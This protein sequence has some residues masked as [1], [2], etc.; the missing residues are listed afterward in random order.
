MAI[1]ISALQK[2]QSSAPSI[3]TLYKKSGIDYDTAL[4]VGRQRNEI[5]NEQFAREQ[6]LKNA[7]EETKKYEAEAEKIRGSLLYKAESGIVGTYNLGKDIVKTVASTGAGIADI[8]ERGLGV[9]KQIEGVKNIFQKEKG[10]KISEAYKRGKREYDLSPTYFERVT[11]KSLTKEDGGVDWEQGRKFIT[12]SMEAPLYAFNAGVVVGKTLLQRA[13]ARVSSKYFATQVGAGASLQ[14]AGEY[15]EGDT[16]GE[17]ASNFGKNLVLNALLYLGGETLQGEIARKVDIKKAKESLS[18]IESK[19]GKLDDADR[20]NAL[21]ALESGVPEEK[22]IKSI[23][24]IKNEEVSAD[25]LAKKLNDI[26]DYSPENPNSLL[27]KITIEKDP[28]K[29]APL[30]EGK[31]APEDIPTVSRLLKNVETEESANAILKK[32][33]PDIQNQKLIEDISFA[34]TPEQVAR[35]LKGKA[36]D[37]TIKE[38]SPILAEIRDEGDIQRI[39]D[40][41]NVKAKSLTKAEGEL[42]LKQPTTTPP[43][44]SK[45]QLQI[46][47]LNE[48]LAKISEEENALRL[49]E[50]F[51]SPKTR[52]INTKIK[53]LSEELENA[54]MKA[55]EASF[56]REFQFPDVEMEIQYQNFKNLPTNV[57]DRIEDASQWKKRT[58]KTAGDIDNTLYSQEYSD[59]EVFDIFKERRLKEVDLNRSEKE[60]NRR[61]KEIEKEIKLLNKQKSELAKPSPKKVETP[62]ETPKPEVK[63]KQTPQPP[64]KQTTFQSL[65]KKTSPELIETTKKIK[66]KSGQKMLKKVLG[67]LEAEVKDMPEYGGMDMKEQA[68]KALRL[69][70]DDYDYAYRIAMGLDNAPKGIKAGSIFNAVKRLAIEKGDID[71]L[72]ALGTSPEMNA[73]KKALGQ[74]VKAFDDTMTDDPTR[75]IDGIIKAQK[76]QI[77]NA[78]DLIKAEEKSIKEAINKIQTSPESF[79]NNI[80]C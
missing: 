69:A 56:M 45:E 43:K 75:V 1:S 51:P 28:E 40:D 16:A 30:L 13:I 74:E 6:L 38:I 52:E 34:E 46:D 33:D 3:S 60:V 27:K 20:I 7:L 17:T 57:L 35:F 71:T 61:M 70:I 24:K 73:F 65:P 44:K 21:D 59:N 53:K 4:N 50:E 58:T 42:D 47:K 68:E 9:R 18:N 76:E 11:G 49:E 19:L 77:K 79:I 64:K 37:K 32:F 41:F 22:L 2:K 26:V 8:G 48:K 63:P 55:M 25:D 23:E 12:S 39:L 29:I 10:E 54:Q 31:I 66:S 67:D 36:D 80:L 62:K 14:T 5:F 15:K 72:I 78:D